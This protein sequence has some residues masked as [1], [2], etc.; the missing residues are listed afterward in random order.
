MSIKT[1]KKV[2]IFTDRQLQMI[3]LL[4][5]KT[6]FKTMAEI[7][8]NAL[9]ND[10]NSNFP[11]YKISSGSAPLIIGEDMIKSKAKF[12]FEMEEEK[13][14]LEIDAK[15]TK[16]EQICTELLFGEV[17]EGSTVGSKVCRWNTYYSNG[18]V[19][20]QK[21]PLMQVGEYLLDNNLFIPTKEAVLKAQPKLKKKLY[22]N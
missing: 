5:G 1:T 19:E 6:G 11:A 9:N 20:S 4:K 22:P 15:F 3:E 12:K 17:E 8:R 18:K 13:K 7:I 16:K 21:L 14:K 10:F 2:I